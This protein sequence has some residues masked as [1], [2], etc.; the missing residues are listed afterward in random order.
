MTL[1]ILLALAFLVLLSVLAVVVVRFATTRDAEGRLTPPGCMAGCA[2]ALALSLLGA[3]GLAVFAGAALFVSAPT[4]EFRT[5]MREAAEDIGEGLRELGDALHEGSDELRRELR[6]EAE[7]VRRTRRQRDEPSSAS[8]AEST[9]EPTET[10]LDAAV[11]WR[12]RVVVSWPGASDPREELLQALTSA[13]LAPP[14]DVAVVTTNDETDG[15]RT[16]A[17]LS[18][19][20]RAANVKELDEL[21]C[22]ELAR[23]S[24]RL[25][26]EY[27]LESVSDDELR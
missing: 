15:A 7:A 21:L 11:Q 25:G 19:A 3:A 2:V 13:A 20:T 5:D 8:T 24:E 12:A 4:E 26:L 1:L 9:P 10:P 22:D 23:L 6:E 18:A 27:S 16:V 17:T 14:V